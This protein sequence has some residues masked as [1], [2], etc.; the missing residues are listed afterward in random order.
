MRI[1]KTVGALALG[2]G[3]AAAAQAQDNTIGTAIYITGSTAFRQQVFNALKDLG[4]TVAQSGSGGNNN[5]TLYGTISDATSGQ[6]LHLGTVAPGLTGQ[7]VTVYGDFSGSAEGVQALVTPGSATYLNTD[8]GSF[9]HTGADLAF[10]DVAQSATPDSPVATGVTLEEVQ[11][12]FDATNHG[13]I[14]GTGVAVQ[15]F[16]FVIN[17]TAAAIKNVTQQ[18][19]QDLFHSGGLPLCFFTGNSSDFGTTVTPVGRYNLSGTRITTILDCGA[20]LSQSLHQYALSD[21]GTTTPGLASTD[22]ASPPSDGNQWVSVGNNG[23]FSGGNVGKAIHASSINSAP[24]AVAYLGF[25]DAG[26]KLTATGGGT[27]A[28]EGPVNFN[29][30]SSWVG[31][32]FPSGNWNLNGVENG[33]YT[34][35]SYERLYASPSDSSSSFIV[36]TFGPGLIDALQYEIVNTTPLTACLESQMNVYRNSDGGDVLHY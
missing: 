28:S 24:P 16:S 22:T 20:K 6:A 25:A 4:L 1:N 36:G 8:T 27:A 3:L 10:S 35:W 17:G 13:G 34:F 32:T 30:Q 21:N 18:N 15:A 29:G 7:A 19:F 5:F 33:S 12:P 26:S 31:G 9:T 14:P 11:L 2:L 23:Y